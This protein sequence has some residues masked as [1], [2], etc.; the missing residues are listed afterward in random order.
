V[1]HL[2][3]VVFE[4]ALCDVCSRFE[5]AVDGRPEQMM[6]TGTGRPVG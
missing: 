3:I 4:Y 1:L 2:F 5:S 6:V